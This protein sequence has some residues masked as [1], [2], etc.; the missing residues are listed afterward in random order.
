MFPGGEDLPLFSG[1]AIR[2]GEGAKNTSSE[3]KGPNLGF[4]CGACFDTGRV[5]DKFCTCPAGVQ[6]R[7]ID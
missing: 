7:Q 6:A 5:G 1:T 2:V 4:K 3:H